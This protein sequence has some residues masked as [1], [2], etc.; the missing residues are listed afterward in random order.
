MSAGCFVKTPFFEPSA[1]APGTQTATSTVISGPSGQEIARSIQRAAAASCAL[2]LAAE[3][4][5][6]VG[7]RAR[8]NANDAT[9]VISCVA[10]GASRRERHVDAHAAAFAVLDADD[11]G[12][13][14]QVRQRHLLTA[15]PSLNFFWMPS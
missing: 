14:D 9:S 2:R 8:G 12:E 5:K 4:A 1:L 10:S 11:A 6:T 15:E 7:R 13:H 3:V